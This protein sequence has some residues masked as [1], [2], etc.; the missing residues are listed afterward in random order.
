MSPISAVSGNACLTF[1]LVSLYIIHNRK[2]MILVLLTHLAQ[3]FQYIPNC[4]A[5]YLRVVKD[6]PRYIIYIIASNYTVVT[7]SDKVIVFQS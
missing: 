6:Q 5:H 4:W 7:Y 3:L 2:K 1:K